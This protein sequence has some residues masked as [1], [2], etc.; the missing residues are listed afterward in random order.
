MHLTEALPESLLK[1]K[2]KNI[3]ILYDE[4]DASVLRFVDSADFN[5]AFGCGKCCKGF[6]PDLLPLEAAYIA[7][8]LISQDLEKAETICKTGLAP[9]ESLAATPTCPLYLPESPYHCSVYEARPLVCRLFGFSGVSDKNNDL[10]FSL[11]RFMESASLENPERKFRIVQNDP[12]FPIKP[13]AMSVFGER[14][15]SLDPNDSGM[16]QSLH[17]AVPAAIGRILFLVSI[18]QNESQGKRGSPQ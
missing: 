12:R 15:Q 3:K 2:L 13:P 11:C 16:R 14:L 18:G 4:V 7:G 17:K 9:L 5:C 6:L 10:S 1:E 8:F